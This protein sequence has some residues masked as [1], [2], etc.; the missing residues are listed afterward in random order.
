MKHRTTNS[1][2]KT[3]LVGLPPGEVYGTTQVF[4][5]NLDVDD[6]IG[7][8]RRCTKNRCSGIDAHGGIE[9]ANNEIKDSYRDHLD[10][11]LDSAV[12][13]GIRGV[14]VRSVVVGRVSGLG[15]DPSR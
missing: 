3:T 9:T 4:A 1:S 2:P 15:G 8:D 5:T 14:V 6:E 7:L 10:R 11:V 13:L 12:S